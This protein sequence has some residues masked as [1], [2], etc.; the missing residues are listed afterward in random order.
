[1]PRIPFDA[2][3]ADSR[4]WAFPSS[5]QLSPEEEEEMLARVDAFLD[6]WAAHGTP[7]TAGRE[8]KEGRFL[9]VAV[10]EA[11]APPSGCSIDSLARVLKDLGKAWR[12]SFLDHAPVWFRSGGGELRSASRIEFRALAD[13]GEVDVETPVF[14]NT[15][16]RMDQ[17][18]KGEWEKAAGASWHRRAFFS[19]APE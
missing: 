17:L 16:S 12:M 3:P 5:R 18:R 10:D 1:M 4:L 8:W 11:T 13:A 14:D 7:L 19:A 6:G 2:L 9:F 15:I